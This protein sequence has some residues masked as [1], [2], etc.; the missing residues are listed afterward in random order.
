MYKLTLLNTSSHIVTLEHA[1]GEFAF[2]AIAE[3]NEK[4]AQAYN[5]ASGF[6]HLLFEAAGLLSSNLTP[7]DW[8]LEMGRAIESILVNWHEQDFGARAVLYAGVTLSNGKVYVCTAGDCRIHLV[9]N[10]E[11]IAVTRDHNVI[12]DPVEGFAMSDDERLLPIY[13]RAATRSIGIGSN[14]RLPEC[15]T[16]MAESEHTVLIS[17]SNFHWYRQPAEY[18]DSFLQGRPKLVSNLRRPTGVLI[19]IESSIEMSS[20]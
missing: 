14:G 7:E 11:L 12:D 19:K 10:G 5:E 8:P 13:Q 6:K 18:L 1:T 3:A 4:D 15:Q 20:L 17:S 9:K 2:C 16:W